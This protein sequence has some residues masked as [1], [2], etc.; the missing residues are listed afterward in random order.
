L[1]PTRP[2]APSTASR[3]GP[4]SGISINA[5]VKVRT[6]CFDPLPKAP[7]D[8]VPS[9]PAFAPASIADPGS[10]SIGRRSTTYDVDCDQDGFFSTSPVGHGATEQDAIDDLLEQLESV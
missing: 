2:S 9:D 8:G 6:T 1:A 4:R 7:R 5:H 3:S 10:T